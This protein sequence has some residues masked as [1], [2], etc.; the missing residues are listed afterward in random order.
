MRFQEYPPVFAIAIALWLTFNEIIS[1]LE[2]MEDIG[3][4]IPPFLKPVM[5]MMREKV[6]DHMEQLGGEQ[7]E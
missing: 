4:P 2:N 1:V 3:T 7:D 6:N 5:K